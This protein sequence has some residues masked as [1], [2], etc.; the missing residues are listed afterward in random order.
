[1]NSATSSTTNAATAPTTTAA[2]APQPPQL[3][4]PQPLSQVPSRPPEPDINPFSVPQQRPSPF[5]SLDPRPSFGCFIVHLLE[6]CPKQV[7]VCFGCGKTLKPN[8]EIAQPPYNLVIVSNAMRSYTDKNGVQREKQGN[9][10]FHLNQQCLQRHERC[11]IS[12]LVQVKAEI[13]PLLSQS[14]I[15]VLRLFGVII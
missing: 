2:T 1:M 12:S 4:P 15:A 13:R 7:R 5:F 11:F 6:H 10:Y 14:H 8:G 3:A 9:V